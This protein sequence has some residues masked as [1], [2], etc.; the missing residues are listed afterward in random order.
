M[1]IPEH[2]FANMPLSADIGLQLYSL[3][4]E[5]KEDLPGSLEKIAAI[6]YQNLEAAGYQDGKFYGLA[7][8]DFKSMVED[9]GMKLLSSHLTFKKDEV[10]T[11]LQAHREAGIKYMVWPWLS[12]E[13]RKSLDSYKEIV[14]G[15]N[16]VGQM[17]KDNGLRFGYHN[18]DFEFYPING[19]I[20]YDMMLELTDPDLVF[21]QIDLYWAVYAGV[22]PLAYFEKYPGRF[23]LW[24]VKDMKAGEGKEMTE[25][26]TGIIDYKKL[27]EYSPL[28]GMKD[29]FI[30]QD[31]IIGDGFES[32]KESFEY[33]N[34]NL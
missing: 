31:T 2:L 3:R 21:M 8:A 6:G 5:I 9:Y 34:N 30:E 23:E 32:V 14:E 7:P 22:D 28:A 16:V 29:F 15:F 25:V 20:P 17:C 11:V 27:F 13:Q 1:L 33:L 19:T 24:H 4:N 10:G 12:S 18:H 26:G